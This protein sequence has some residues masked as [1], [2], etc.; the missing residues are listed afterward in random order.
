MQP[1]IIALVLVAAACHTGWNFL[2]KDARG[3]TG[4]VWLSAVAGAVVPLPALI[5]ALA[6]APG[7]LGTVAVI[8]MAVS[9]A[10]HAGYF[11][12]LQRGYRDGDLSFVYPVAR[13]I[14]PMVAGLLAVLLLG[15]RP[16]PIG[17]AGAVAII[18]SILV[19]ARGG[20]TRGAAFAVLTGVA[21]GAYTAWDKHA[22]DGLAL[23]PVVY[24]WG[25]NLANIA[26]LSPWAVSH[27]AQVREAWTESRG[28]ALGVGVLSPLAYVLVLF[29]LVEAPVMAVAPAR[30]TSIVMATLLGTGVLAEGDPGRRALASVGVLLGV[31]ALALG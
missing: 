20:S 27:R 23:S 14:G 16:G 11:V 6:V 1:Q 21:I 9:G 13:G 15:E 2:A 17:L 4:F 3:G 18:G 30:E 22:V 31:V 10:L 19:L 7:P 26:V 12:S 5:V 29:A 25:T 24:Y 28:R 8:A